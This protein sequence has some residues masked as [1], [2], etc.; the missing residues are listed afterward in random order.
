MFPMYS[1]FCF[2]W[3][4][5][6]FFSS[7]SFS[8]GN[9]SPPESSVIRYSIADFDGAEPSSNAVACNN[10]LRLASYMNREEFQV[11]ATSLLS[12]FH[13][14]LSRN[15]VTSHMP[16]LV[17]ALMHYHDST[18]QVQKRKKCIFGVKKMQQLN[19]VS[20]VHGHVYSRFF[21]FF[22]YTS[23]ARKTQA[24]PRNCCRWFARDCCLA[25]YWF[26]RITSS[27][28]MFCSDAARWLQRWSRWMDVPPLTFAIITRARYQSPSQIDLQTFSMRNDNY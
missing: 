23:L 16:Q 27:R 22:R 8:H 18:T 25:A 26:W 28:T 19:L 24:T 11:K 2:R 6:L 13:E 15:S 10:L 21:F 4:S 20:Q 1:Q 12:Y 3:S 14:P 5:G 9:K 7:R 17:S